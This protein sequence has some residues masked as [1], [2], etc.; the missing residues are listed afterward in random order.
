V[1]S[2]EAAL[3]PLHQLLARRNAVKPPAAAVAEDWSRQGSIGEEGSD[4]VEPGAGYSIHRAEVARKP[5]PLTKPSRSLRHASDP[6]GTASGL[7]GT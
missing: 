6:R 7:G 2:V 1:G 3:L 5:I 4:E